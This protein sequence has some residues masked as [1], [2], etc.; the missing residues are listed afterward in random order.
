MKHFFVLALALVTVTARAEVSAV[1][2]NGLKNESGLGFVLTSGNTQTETLSVN[3]LNSYT[4]GENLFAFKAN[5]MNS[6]QDSVTSAQNY[7]L[8]LRYER[9]IVP[10]FSI[11]IAQGLFADKFQNIRQ[12]HNSDIG[13]KFFFYKEDAI[14]WFAEAGYRFTRENT[15]NAGSHNLNYVRTYTEVEKKWN[16]TVS[17][18]YW[19]EYLPNL[20]NGTDWLLNTEA[21]V[22]AML[23]GIFSIKTGYLVRF[24]HLPAAAG[25]KKTDTTLTTAL[26]AKF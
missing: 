15:T 22:S 10:T 24:D 12:R 6:R 9:S 23:S 7:L 25:L 11:Y 17:T 20:T 19:I 13:G 1:P 16:P 3:Q 26:V 2:D 8:N 5:Y 21:S 18:K 14:N 4:F